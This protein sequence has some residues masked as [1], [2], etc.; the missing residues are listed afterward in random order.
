MKPGDVWIR[1]AT[2]VAATYGFS[3]I[4]MYMVI[5]SGETTYVTAL[6]GLAYSESVSRHLAGRPAVVS[7][8]RSIRGLVD[9]PEPSAS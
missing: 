5:S 1:I 2:F 7:C 4:F 8:S 9:S 3:A 6:G